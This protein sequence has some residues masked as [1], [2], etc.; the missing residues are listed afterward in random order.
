M[1]LLKEY[2]KI[3]VDSSDSLFIDTTSIGLE[4][5]EFTEFHKRH[6]VS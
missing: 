2:I 6:Y 1:F 5:E 3:I 4:G